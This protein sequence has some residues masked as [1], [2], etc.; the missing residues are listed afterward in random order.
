MNHEYIHLSI[1]FCALI[2]C[3][4]H[5]QMHLDKASMYLSVLHFQELFSTY[6]NVLTAYSCMY[7]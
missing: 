2:T 4:T 7:E 6:L 3:H 1:Y 5:P